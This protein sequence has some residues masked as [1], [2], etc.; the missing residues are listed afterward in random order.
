MILPL[1]AGRISIH[2]PPKTR[3]EASLK[4]HEK[5]RETLRVAPRSAKG[6]SKL[7]PGWDLVIFDIL[8]QV[9]AKR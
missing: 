1:N 3:L 2:L 5:G 4:V 7:V 6:M 9:E 8:G